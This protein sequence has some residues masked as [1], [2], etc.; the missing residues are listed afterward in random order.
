MTIEEEESV[1]SHPAT[2]YVQLRDVMRLLE[3]EDFH[4]WYKNEF[5]DYITGETEYVQARHQI[6][7]WLDKKLNNGS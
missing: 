3:S 2:S 7:E 1:L 5:E 4:Q 6:W